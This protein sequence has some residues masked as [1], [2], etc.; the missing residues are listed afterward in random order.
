MRFHE[1]VKRLTHLH[2]KAAVAR[3]AGIT[4]LALANIVAGKSVPSLP[5]AKAI[6]Q[7]L[8]VSLEWLTDDSKDW[9]PVRREE[10]ARR[11]PAPAA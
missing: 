5:T 7:V 1:K 3:A 4:P 10:T 11:D 2:H 9:P 6:A 8:C